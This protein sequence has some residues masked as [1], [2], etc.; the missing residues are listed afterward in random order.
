MDLNSYQTL[1]ISTNQLRLNVRSM[2][3]RIH[4]FA[5]QRRCNV[6]QERYIYELMREFN[7]VLKI[8]LPS[9]LFPKH[10]T[11]KQEMTKCLT[12]LNI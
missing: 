4:V 2:K 12:K 10:Q 8:N 5:L 3:T 6:N 9:V 7:P 11:R 1:Q